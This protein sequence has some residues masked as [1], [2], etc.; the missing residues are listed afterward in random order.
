M[1]VRSMGGRYYY[2]IGNW[3]SPQLSESQVKTIGGTFAWKKT[4]YRT[5]RESLERR[6][7]DVLGRA[8]TN[9]HIPAYAHPCVLPPLSL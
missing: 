6:A 4:R 2:P 8:Q 3:S 9:Q 7:T 5:R 1:M